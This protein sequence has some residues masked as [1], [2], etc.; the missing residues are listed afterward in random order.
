VPAGVQVDQGVP[1][2]PANPARQRAVEVVL[3]AVDLRRT[4]FGRLKY[5][6]GLT[7]LRVRR[8]PRVTLH[9]NLTILAQLAA[10]VTRVDARSVAV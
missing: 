5:D 4:G 10:A 9:V 1:A 3:P 6:Y 2:A 7:P 8:L